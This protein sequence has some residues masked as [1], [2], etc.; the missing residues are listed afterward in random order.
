MEE[1]ERLSYEHG[2][3][4]TPAL[5]AALGDATARLMAHGYVRT[6]RVSIRVASLMMFTDSRCGDC[7][8]LD[9]VH[10]PG[11]SVAGC[12][13]AA[14]RSVVSYFWS[15]ERRSEW[16]T[17]TFAVNARV[18]ASQLAFNLK[19]KAIPAQ[20]KYITNGVAIP[21]PVEVS[22]SCLRESEPEEE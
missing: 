13:C 7:G 16:A 5:A 14:F 8:H 11:C 3:L 22:F 10:K 4:N 15:D 19:E 17:I 18:A 6:V 20:T 9:I 1:L 2:A 21:F 12:G